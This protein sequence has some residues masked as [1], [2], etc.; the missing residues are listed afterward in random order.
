MIN[1]KHFLVDSALIDR[2]TPSIWLGSVSA[3]ADPQANSCV[4][5][6]S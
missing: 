3:T 1:G 5:S 2:P 4:L 6:P